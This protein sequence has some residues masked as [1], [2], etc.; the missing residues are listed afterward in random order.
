M[1]VDRDVLGAFLEAHPDF[2]ISSPGPFFRRGADGRIEPG[3]KII[4]VAYR[5]RGLN[6]G[7]YIE[8]VGASVEEAIRAI[9]AQIEAEHN[10]I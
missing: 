2:D 8:G 5:S 4:A 7:E 1:D 9:E 10:H 6:A 3:D